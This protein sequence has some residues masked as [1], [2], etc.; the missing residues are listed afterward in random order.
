MKTAFIVLLSLLALLIDPARAQDWAREQVDNSPRHLEWV[1]LQAG[2]R[3]VATFVAYPERAEK[4]PAVVLI[5]EIF[6]HTN[7]FRLMS[8]HLAAAGYV[9]VVPDLLSGMAPDGQGTDG[10]ESVTEVRKAVGELPPEQVTDDLRAAVE[11]ARNIPAANGKVVLAGF[12]W[13]GTQTFRFATNS[14]EI[15]AG[16]VF[17]GTAPD[18]REALE[19]ISAPIY[20]FYAE[21]DARVNATLPETTSAME[22][23][24]KVFEIETYAGG[25]HGFMRAGE[26]P[27]AEEG[28]KKAR[29]A[30]WNRTLEL[31]A[32]FNR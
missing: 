24:G 23:L 17:Y 15:D 27:E 2:D 5:H 7:W 14:D 22:E 3:E 19:R 26:A 6:G 12:C 30:A 10:F 11:Y 28:N 25:G 1:A 9:V 18:D 16:F 4:A 8:D 31:L 13:G 20:G 21:N 32:L 29:E